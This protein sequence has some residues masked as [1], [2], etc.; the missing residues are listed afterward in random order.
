MKVFFKYLEGEDEG[1]LTLTPHPHPFFY[2][3][4]LHKKTIILTT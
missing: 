2:F 3:N 4:K 1:P